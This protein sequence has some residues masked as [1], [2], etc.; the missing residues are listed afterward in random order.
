[1][2]HRMSYNTSKTGWARQGEGEEERLRKGYI[3]RK[4]VRVMKKIFIT[5][6]VHSYAFRCAVM[7]ILTPSV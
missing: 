5:V 3:K 7:T 1:M 4:Y 6:C 2:P